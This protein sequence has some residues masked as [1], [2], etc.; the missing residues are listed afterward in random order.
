VISRGSCGEVRQALAVYVL[1]AIEP[2]DRTLVDRHLGDCADCREEL[3]G[4]APLPAL[5]RRVPLQEASTLVG[6]D[7][8]G[9]APDDQ[10]PGPAL[11][12]LL[13][14]AERRRRRDLRTHAATAAAVG[15]VAGA[16]LI[17]AWDAAHQIHLGGMRPR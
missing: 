17:A 6:N 9:S 13:A 5:L 11:R 2:A 10:P 1:G 3:A 16:G 4:F 7:A 12:H 15:L 14:Q 8:R